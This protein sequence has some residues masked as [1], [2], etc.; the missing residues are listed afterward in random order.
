[1]ITPKLMVFTTVVF[2]TL[3]PLAFAQA[4][5]DP[6]G[7]QPSAPALQGPADHPSSA[8]WMGRFHHTDRMEFMAKKLGITDEQQKKMRQLSVGF[9][10][11]T[12]KARMGLIALK[13]E[14]RTML[15]SGKVDQQKLA[16]MDD[17][18]VKLVSE[19]MTERLKMR[20]D[21]LALLTPDQLDKLGD[22]VAKKAFHSR[23]KKIH[24]G[25]GR[26]HFAGGRF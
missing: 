3:A 21:R 5:Q 12:R 17:Q 18:K 26:D 13:D 10:D 20:R 2:L 6:A 14:K 11:R 23:F 8:P 1:M 22:L 25:A 9:Q 24:R 15:M 7:P 19:V 4:P 16:Q